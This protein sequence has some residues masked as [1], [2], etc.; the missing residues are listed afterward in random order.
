MHLS[1]YP[2]IRRPWF[3][4]CVSRAC[5]TTLR[6][7]SFESVL[8]RRRASELSQRAT[9][10][11]LVAASGA[12]LGEDARPVCD[13]AEAAIRD[14]QERIGLGHLEVAAREC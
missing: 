7:A 3:A 11:F 6:L 1:I 10:Q 5:V 9:V 4:T 2:S 14:G 8:P 13:G 12:L